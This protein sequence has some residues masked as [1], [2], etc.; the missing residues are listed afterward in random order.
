MSRNIIKRQTAS[1]EGVDDTGN[2][3]TPDDYASQIIKLIPT[4][5]VGVYL[6]LSGLFAAKEGTTDDGDLKIVFIAQSISFLVILV[7]TPFYLKKAA[8]ITDKAQRD[9]AFIS[10]IVW[11]ISL[12]G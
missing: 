3:P 12:G 7:I 6:G 11:A 4:E 8:N 1:L 10:Y 9:V 2:Q 5:I